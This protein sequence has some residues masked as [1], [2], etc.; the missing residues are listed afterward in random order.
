M[1]FNWKDVGNAVGKIAPVLGTVVGGPAGGAVGALISQALGTENNPESVIKALS[2]DP[3][4]AIKLKQLEIDK[5][6]LLNSHI[7]QI[8]QIELDYVKESVKDK[9]S[10]RNREVEALKSGS[11]NTTQN[12]LAIIGVLAFFGLA[13]YV[14]T[15]GIPNMSKEESFIIGTV[16]GSVMMIGKEI[17]GYYFGSSS[18]SKEKTRQMG[19]K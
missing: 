9:E 10:A 8:A 14:V 18:G 7:E 5:Q 4:V 16:V 15:V 6:E 1:S 3:E 13:F 11:G 12:L 2:T 19:S 17:Y